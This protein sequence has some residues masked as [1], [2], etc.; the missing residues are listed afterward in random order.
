[1]NFERS[2]MNWEEGVGVC[3]WTAP[4]KEELEA[5]FRKASVPFEKMVSVEEHEAH[6]LM[7]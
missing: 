3:C 1:M 2:F 4:S 5:L 7:K 6:T